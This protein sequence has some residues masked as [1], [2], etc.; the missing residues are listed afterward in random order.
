MKKLFYI[1][2]LGLGLGISFGLV[3]TGQLTAA[4]FSKPSPD[5]MEKGKKA[6]VTNCVS[7]HGDLGDGNGPA[8]QFLKP[9]PRDFSKEAFKNG[10]KPE[11]IFSTITKGLPGTLMVGYAHL[12]E[13]TRWALAHYVKS[14]RKK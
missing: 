2:T 8:G 10:D 13:E 7:C 12:P 5:L 4:D 6:Y 14:L 11:E 1:K 9:K 3:T